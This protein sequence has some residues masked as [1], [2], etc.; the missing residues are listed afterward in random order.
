MKT[1]AEGQ[2]KR[3]IF[4]PPPW[5]APPSGLHPSGLHPS[6]L[7]PSGLH[8]SGT[9]L[10]DP[11]L[12]GPHPSKAT[13]VTKFNIQKLA[14]V[15]IGRNRSPPPNP[16]LRPHQ[17]SGKLSVNELVEPPKFNSGGCFVLPTPGS[18]TR[19][20]TSGEPRLCV[21]PATSAGS[22][23]RPSN[24]TVIPH[25]L[26]LRKCLGLAPIKKRQSERP[27]CAARQDGAPS[28]QPMHPALASASRVAQSPLSLGETSE[29]M[30]RLD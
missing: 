25:H 19:S 8:P 4:R 24:E 7:H 22:H 16:P 18:T 9:T 17:N 29:E 15:E 14:E 21:C 2:K 11:T 13:L 12:R 26:M 20:Q 10:G 30:G 28:P 1:V 3:E 5:R 23:N 27:A 6:G